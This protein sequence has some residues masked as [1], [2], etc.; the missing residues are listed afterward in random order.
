ML[1]RADPPPL[2]RIG[3]LLLSLTGS[4]STLAAADTSSEPETIELHFRGSYA[5]SRNFWSL[6]DEVRAASDVS[7]AQAILETHYG[8]PAE[9]LAQLGTQVYFENVSHL[10]VGIGAEALIGGDARNPVFPEIRA[11]SFLSGYGEFGFGTRLP[12]DQYGLDWEVGLRVGAGSRESIDAPVTALLGSDPIDR[13]LFVYTGPEFK[14]GANVDV[15]GIARWRSR[16]ALRPTLYGVRSYDEGLAPELGYQSWAIR[17]RSMTEVLFKIE[18]IPSGMSEI[19]LVTLM[20][21]QPLPVDVLPRVW[22]SVHH[23]KPFPDWRQLAG[24][25]LVF[26]NSQE[27]HHFSLRVTG[28]IFGGYPGGGLEFSLRDGFGSI[29][30]WGVEMSDGYQLIGHS[31]GAATVGL[32]L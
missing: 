18:T 31:F 7:R 1:Y 14:F 26:R 29:G 32:K 4:W 16:M 2:L 22:D 6:V 24:L 11:Y 17:W 9:R 20:G 30:Y 28:G 10:W 21:Q 3:L 19:G 25:G 8:K 27:R 5:Q 23:L 15:F 13:G 12:E